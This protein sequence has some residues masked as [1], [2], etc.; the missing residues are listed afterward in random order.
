MSQS[1]AVESPGWSHIGSFLKQCRAFV[2]DLAES[3]A[4]F[5]L[6]LRVLRPE[7]SV[8]RV[9]GLCPIFAVFSDWR[10]SYRREDSLASA[11]ARESFPALVEK[12]I[13]LVD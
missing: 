13:D 2:P 1:L 11:F 4:R 7:H 10:F 12:A 9:F 6:R 8:D 5:D 3:M